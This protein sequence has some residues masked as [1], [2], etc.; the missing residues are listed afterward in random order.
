M[1]RLFKFISE[2]ILRH[3]IS[4]VILFVISFTL[5]QIMISGLGKELPQEIKKNSYL[6]L[7]LG[8]LV[9][10]GP[11]QL[12]PDQLITTIL[13]GDE[14]EKIFLYEL[15]EGIELAS[16]DDAIKGLFL[17]NS[18][19]SVGY[20]NGMATVIEI[21][22]ALNRFKSKK[23]IIGYVEEPTKLDYL[24]FST[25]DKLFMNPFGGL[26]LNGM[27]SEI[28]YLGEAL[29]QLGIE[30][31]APKSG[32]YKSATEPLTQDSMSPENREQISKLL[33][34]RWDQMLRRYSANRDMELSDLKAT[35]EKE[36]YYQAEE[37]VQLG[38]VDEIAYFDEVLEYLEEN[39]ASDE[40]DFT[41]EQVSMVSY[42]R[43]FE[44]SGKEPRED[45]IAVVYVE[46]TI[47]NGEMGSAES[48]SGKKVAKELRMIRRK[49]SAKGVVLRI[50]SPGGSAFASEEILRE[51]YK[52]REAEI[53]VVV[54]LGSIAA[55]GGYWI[56]M[57][58]DTIFAEASTITGSIGVFG[59][60]P[61]IKKL[62]NHYGLNW[63]TVKTSPYAD[64]FT[65]SRPKTNVE[66]DKIQEWVDTIYDKFLKRVSIGRKLSLTEVDL[67]AQGRV[68]SGQD[69][70]EVGLIDYFGGILDAIDHCAEL[71]KISKFGVD[72]YPEK[73]NKMDWIQEFLTGEARVNLNE[74]IQMPK[75]PIFNK[76]GK[77]LE[78][79]HVLQ[80]SDSFYALFPF[81]IE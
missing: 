8:I 19:P 44:L 26:M 51:M 81:I 23:P 76:L 35:V 62:G 56:A 21:Q 79:F 40:E 39:G 45:R 80:D 66:M 58:S 16:K 65:I 43:N 61:N 28:L 50:N 10:D 52:L 5:L 7:D 59:L 12:Q 24:L 20:S 54:S 17:T 48:V 63:E 64:L 60:M 67:I 9:S 46:G 3:L 70:K 4:L 69:A 57:E 18:L 42:L 74:M 72:H 25:A 29:S 75:N 34:S 78:F 71:A 41:F 32:K 6:V 47:V 30:I 49:D 37:A 1:K 77:E 31:Q 73:K 15:L 11:K 22:D 55:S 13:S 53:P 27:A 14:S 36:P 68:W 33:E 38:F 2:S